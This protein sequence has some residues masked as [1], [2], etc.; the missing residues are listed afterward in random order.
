[1]FDQFRNYNKKVFLLTNSYWEYT[2]VVMNYLEGKKT[3]EKKDF[4]WMD[5]FDMII[6]GGNK[7][8]F[9]LD[10]GYSFFLL[11]FASLSIGSLLLLFVFFLEIL[12]QPIVLIRFQV[13]YIIL[14]YYQL[15]Q[16]IFNNLFQKEKYFKV[17]MLEHF[18]NCY[19]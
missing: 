10:E 6:V 7:P 15:H 8:A 4:Q 5:H 2:N 13:S 12:F 17:V 16:K 9:M 3:G 11:V 19:K 14:N 18:I 1:M